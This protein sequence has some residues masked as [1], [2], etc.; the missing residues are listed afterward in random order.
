MCC[1]KISSCSL[2]ACSSAA[3]WSAAQLADF[4]RFLVFLRLQ[5]FAARE[6]LAAQR[7]DRAEVLDIQRE[8]AIRQPLGN[9]VE[10]TPEI[11]Q[12]VHLS[13]GGL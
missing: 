3:I 1:W 8:A 10:I 6:R 13:E 12:I 7:V 4:L 2:A 11:S 9:G 5:L